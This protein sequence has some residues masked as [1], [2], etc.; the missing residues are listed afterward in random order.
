MK[1]KYIYLFIVLSATN[2]SCKKF[3]DTKPTDF[4]QQETYYQNEAQLISALAGVYDPLGSYSQSL[5]SL[6]IPGVLSLTSDDVYYRF[7]P[8]T[9]QASA[10]NS[11]D[12]TNLY[13]V[14]FWEWCYKGIERANVLLA[15]IDRVQNI[16]KLSKD[17]VTGEAKF[18]R[19]YYHFLLVQNF[20]DI[21]LKITPTTDPSIVNV[22]RTPT[23][24]VYDQILKDM[25]EAEALVFPGYTQFGNSSSR[26]TK[27]IVQGVL[28]RVCLFMAGFP[29]QD[30]T[31]YA[32]ALAW[33][34]K[35]E[36]SGIHSL[37]TGYEP[38]PV[39]IRG[40]IGDS[41]MYN[42][43]NNNP[44][45]V[46]NPYSQVFLYESRGEYYIKENMWEVDFNAN[47]IANESGA[48]GGLVYG[49]E[50]GSNFSLLGRCSNPVGTHQR[51]YISYGAG[52]LRRDWNCAPYS[53]NA[54]PARAFITANSPASGSLMGRPCAKWRREY[55]PIASG[56]VD[57]TA[58]FT[59]IKYPLLRYADVL[60]MKAEAENQTNGPTAV[61]FDAVNQIRRRAF[62]IVNGTAPIRAIS[63]TNQG[64]GYT[65]APTVTISG[66][67]VASAT[68]TITAGRVTAISIRN[69]GIGFSVAPIITITGG[70][71]TGALATATIY[72]NTDADLPMSLSK[73]A[74]QD[75]IVM[76]RY[77]EFPGESLRRNDLIRWGIYLST[78]QNLQNYNNSTGIAPTNTTFVRANL[79][80]SNTLAGGS[81]FL[82]FPIPSTEIL[83]NKAM[84]QNP[85]W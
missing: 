32:E 74:M 22:P 7:I 26:I 46:N 28:A 49:I 38:N 60:L 85:G 84:T 56:A 19:A 40:G 68:A 6:G 77:R 69:A 51:L 39:N 70:G 31:K 82:F 44:G 1:F 13:I 55:E 37:N 45:Y 10:N 52:D 79:M 11:H 41:L 48:I 16:N 81:K 33:T 78:F 15:N 25:T 9:Q 66:T 64:S 3:L 17:A 4:L 65:S 36:A 63:I 14:G 35:V 5:Y 8:T 59:S 75:S 27:T 62:G 23:K 61:A 43:T 42:A 58:W 24:Q 2:F 50:C 29:L 57:K 67:N 21:P 30:N 72:A 53:Y 71:G 83:V 18:L 34:N 80:I 12:F 76:E 47:S 73:N 54:V 20:G